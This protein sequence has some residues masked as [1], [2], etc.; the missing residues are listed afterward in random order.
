M[1]GAGRA[2]SASSGL[3]EPCPLGS[4]SGRQ[5]HAIASPQC[6]RRTLEKFEINDNQN[7]SRR[8]EGQAN[9]QGRS[10][11]DI[12]GGFD[13]AAVDLHDPLGDS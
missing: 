10:R 6:L 13:G 2:G 7:G 3:A 8:Y 9:G 12:A 11:A 5:S 4:P 1:S